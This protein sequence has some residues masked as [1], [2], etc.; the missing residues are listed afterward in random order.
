MKAID[1][2][3]SIGAFYMKTEKTHI[4]YLLLKEYLIYIVF[5][6]TRIY[7]GGMYRML[8]AH[9]PFFF[10]Y[11]KNNTKAEMLLMEIK[12]FFV[13]KLKTANDKCSNVGKGVTN[14]PQNYE[15]GM[16]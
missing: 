15:R 8:H 13:L 6:Q 5:C 3:A 9:S 11:R 7:S 14:N 1:Q 16:E 4:I 12:Y 2:H 10:C